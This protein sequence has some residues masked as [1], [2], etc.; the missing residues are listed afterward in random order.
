MKELQ[1][2]EEDLKQRPLLQDVVNLPFKLLSSFKDNA[3]G[4]EVT[5]LVLKSLLDDFTKRKGAGLTSDE[6]ND[7]V[8]DNIFRKAADTLH[9]LASGADVP[10]EVRSQS[11]LLQSQF[12]RQNLSLQYA[13][14]LVQNSVAAPGAQLGLNFKELSTLA[15]EVKD[16][17][18][19]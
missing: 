9:A 8:Y 18:E 11:L 16:S 6:I 14:K 15:A 7:V 13:L 4:K 3:Q 1:P 12:V 19:K 2:S 5:M 17:F 10:A